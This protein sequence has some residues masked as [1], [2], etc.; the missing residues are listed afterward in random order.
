[1]IRDMDFEELYQYLNDLYNE[2]KEYFDDDQI[3][4][5][6]DINTNIVRFGNI[7]AF[8]EKNFSTMFLFTSIKC[9]LKSLIII[10]ETYKTNPEYNKYLDKISKRWQI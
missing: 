5:L 8:M 2:L 7:H 3:N 4:D 10:K 6:L 9:I 1:M